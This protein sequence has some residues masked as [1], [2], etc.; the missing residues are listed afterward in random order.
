MYFKILILLVSLSFGSGYLM[1][2]ENCVYATIQFEHDMERD[3]V[4]Y[5][6]FGTLPLDKKIKSYF[7]D[8]CNIYVVD[9]T[10]MLSDNEICYNEKV[11][12]YFK[13]KTG[14]DLIEAF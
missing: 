1:S 7:E 5:Y 12:T 14:K 4:K 9:S 13:S 8:C 3:S 11:A 10:C 6:S 2:N